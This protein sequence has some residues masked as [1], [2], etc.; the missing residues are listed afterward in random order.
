MI[1]KPNQNT[2]EDFQLTLSTQDYTKMLQQV[3]QNQHFIHLINWS[4]ERVKKDFALL[5]SDNDSDI[6][7]KGI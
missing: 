3:N 4:L 6:K 5:F 7:K 2:Q 1:S